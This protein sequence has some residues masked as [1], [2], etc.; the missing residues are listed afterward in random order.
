MQSKCDVLVVGAGPSGSSTARRVAAGG[1]KTLLID[2]KEEI[3]YPVP[4]AE[5]IG[6]YLFPYLP[7][8]EIP[9]NQF[10][11][12]ITGMEYNVGDL[13]VEH[14]SSHWHGY[15]IDRR[16][17]D[18]WLAES[19]TKAGAKLMTNTELVDLKVD[20]E[21]KVVNATL[22]TQKKEVKVYPKIL[23]AADGCESTVLKLL[24]E[25]K[26][27][28]G[29]LGAV[30]SWEMKNLNI[31]KPNIQKLYF[32]DFSPT[33]WGFVFPKSETV[34]NIGIGQI[35]PENNLER[36]F[37]EF[38]ELEPIR[39]MVKDA[40]FVVEKSSK[41]RHGNITDKW[42]YGNV[43]LTGD[44]ATHNIKP[45]Y[46]GILPGIICG[47]A[48][49]EL[50]LNMLKTEVTNDDYVK[51]IKKT[52]D[53]YFEISQALI[54]LMLHVAAMEDKKKFLLMP[55]AMAVC[56]L[57]EEENRIELSRLNKL[58]VLS[59]DELATIL[60]DTKEKRLEAIPP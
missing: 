59:Y 57:M 10:I 52:L 35:F 20:D 9:S 47:Y 11:W 3:G 7:P 37:N 49:G 31:E 42:I 8:I 19:A 16:K 44:A 4:C 23:V 39:K 25:Y 54:P 28:K 26:P 32:G 58:L 45:Y 48:T 53:P 55:I 43:V 29:D 1:A 40:E 30:H 46:E 33:G 38:L 13:S 34:A 2:K 14:T 51:L 24:D 50:T 5:A 17:F 21:G 56:T 60:K 41:I 27:K 36:S 15:S 22:R 12:R 18:K 6:E